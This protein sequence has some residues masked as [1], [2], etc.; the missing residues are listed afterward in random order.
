[1]V[2][3]VYLLV[4][5]PLTHSKAEATPYRGVEIE[6]DDPEGI[7]FVSPS[8]IMVELDSLPA[9]IRTKPR[10]EVNTADISYLLN[11]LDKIE[12][13]SCVKLNNDILRIYVKPMKPVARIFDHGGHSYYVSSTGKRIASD[14]RYHVDVPVVSADFDSLAQARSLLPVLEYIRNDKTADAL[15][16][17]IKVDRHGDI[18][19]IPIIRGHVIN[20]GDNSDIA[21]KWKRLMVMYREVMPVRGWDFYDTLFV[22]WRGQVVATR[23]TKAKAGPSL[24]VLMQTDTLKPEADLPDILPVEA[25][26]PL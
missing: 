9:R 13:A 26:I 19:L 12:L 11:S 25:G 16:S 7:G 24:E 14:L 4:A 18:I 21:N 23:R 15:V 17:S 10:S 8:D 6:V 22:K 3:L 20:F 2:M 5:I 1:M